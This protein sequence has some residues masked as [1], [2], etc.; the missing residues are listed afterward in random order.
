V[1][2][3][4]DFVRAIVENPDD[5]GV[6]LVFA[7]W[8]EDVGETDRSSFIRVQCR[9][10]QLLAVA[11]RWARTPGNRPGGTREDGAAAGAALAE[12]QSLRRRELELMAPGR[13]WWSDYGGDKVTVLEWRR[14]FA[15]RVA[16]QK[17]DWYVGGVG[18]AVVR[19][20]PVRWVR[21]LVAGGGF[22]PSALGDGAIAAIVSDDAI[23]WAK[24]HVLAPGPVRDTPGP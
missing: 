2:T 21:L 15:E 8:L 9:I 12:A 16:V 19:L 7:D 23:T 1:S 5:D 11:E 13:R 18:P 24:A 17:F 20:Q 4:D 6:R 10:H 14:G 22:L 3:Q